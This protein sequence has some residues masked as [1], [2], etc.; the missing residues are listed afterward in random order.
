[1]VG[2]VL[3]EIIKIGIKIKHKKLKIAVLII[4]SLGIIFKFT[5][6]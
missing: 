5:F 2:A 1:M 3:H 6:N 4:S